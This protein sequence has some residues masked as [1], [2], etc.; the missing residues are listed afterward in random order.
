MK[1]LLFA[2]LIVISIG[3]PINLSGQ[4]LP[5]TGGNSCVNAALTDLGDCLTAHHIQFSLMDGGNVIFLIVNP[6]SKPGPVKKCIKNYNKTRKSC[7]QAPEIISPFTGGGHHEGDDDDDDED[8][9]N[10]DDD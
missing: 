4:V 8:D 6:N 2:C 1:K 3:L 5:G 9:C 10:H 7:P